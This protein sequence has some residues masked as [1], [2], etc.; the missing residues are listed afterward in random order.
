[1]IPNH[2]KLSFNKVVHFCHRTPFDAAS[3]CTNSPILNFAILVGKVF[4]SRAMPR[5]QC[6]AQGSLNKQM[7]P[8]SESDM[9]PVRRDREHRLDKLANVVVLFASLY[10]S[11]TT[12]TRCLLNELTA[13]DVTYSKYI[14]LYVHDTT[15]VT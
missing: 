14:T 2:S 11:Y 1:M 7:N 9:L 5:E 13:C 6:N 4:F 12:H 15:K 3:P 8:G 10:Y